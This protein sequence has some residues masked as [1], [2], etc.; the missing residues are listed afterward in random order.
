[1]ESGDSYSF[2][3]VLSGTHDRSNSDLG[4]PATGKKFECPGVTIG[5][6]AN[7]LITENRDYWNLAGL[8]VTA[9]AVTVVSVAA[10]A[11]LTA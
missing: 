9:M 2:E 6:R 7:G 11:P 1:V 3:W 5:V 10:T 8:T 4:I